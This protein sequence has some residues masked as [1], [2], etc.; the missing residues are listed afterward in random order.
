M[1]KTP[2]DLLLLDLLMPEVNGFAVLEYRK[3]KKL[4]FPVL[5][6]SNISDKH[7][8]D[9]CEEFGVSDFLIKSEMDDEQLWPVIMKHLK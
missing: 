1:E 3:E 8:K 9:R 2:P 4:R 6:C 5:V 7:S